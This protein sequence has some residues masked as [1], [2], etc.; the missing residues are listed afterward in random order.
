MIKRP[1]VAIE[2]NTVQPHFANRGGDAT[3]SVEALAWAPTLALPCDLVFVDWRLAFNAAPSLVAS[4][5]FYVARQ[6]IDGSNPFQ[7]H[8][9]H[10]VAVTCGWRTRRS[11]DPAIGG[12]HAKRITG[13]TPR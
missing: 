10:D 11:N 7:E 12:P 4:V 2:D 3:V 5:R 9:Q 6:R 1:S 8:G 13:P